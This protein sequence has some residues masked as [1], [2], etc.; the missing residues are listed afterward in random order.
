MHFIFMIPNQKQSVYEP[1]R[2]WTLIY[3]ICYMKKHKQL[4]KS[5][6]LLLLLQSPEKCFIGSEKE[7][8]TFKVSLFSAFCV[9]EVCK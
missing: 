4:K 3:V 5:L 1:S 8:K 7:K 6:L 2:V 9:W